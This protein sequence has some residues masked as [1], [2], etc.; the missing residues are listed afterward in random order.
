MSI[1]VQISL[2]L[3]KIVTQM[4]HSTNRRKASRWGDEA[5][6]ADDGGRNRDRSKDRS[7]NH[8][9]DGFDNVD[10][11]DGES[12]GRR[13]RE[14]EEEE[15]GEKGG[16]GR[17]EGRWNDSRDRDREWGR[18]RDG[19]RDRYGRRDV[20][21]GGER[22]DQRDRGDRMDRGQRREG[23]ERKNM[24]DDGRVRSRRGD[25]GS[26]GGGGKERAPRWGIADDRDDSIDEGRNGRVRGR[27]EDD[28]DDH[29]LSVEHASR[30]QQQQQ[31]GQRKDVHQKRQRQHQEEQERQKDA[32]PELYGIYD[33]CISK[34]MDFGCFVELKGFPQLGIAKR[35]EGLVHVSQ[36][37]NGMLRDPSKAVK[38]GQPCKVKII[39]SVSETYF[40]SLST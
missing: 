20:D 16:D 17:A 11:E 36:I 10:D 3:F 7:R 25:H 39:S 12:R 6:H 15:G 38:R 22:R 30:M 18:G 35:Q 21:D 29:D 8:S 32:Q 1:S 27:G 37:Q 5:G 24:D 13:R 4:F 40:V 2:H 28:D 26:R 33:G 19:N 14:E 9:K 31:R 34:V 23:D